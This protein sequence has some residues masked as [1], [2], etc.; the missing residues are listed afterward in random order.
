M[1][2]AAFLPAG[3]Q[4]APDLLRDRIILLTGAANG[5]GRALADALAAHGATL[6][7]LDRDVHGLEAAYDA[8]VAAGHPEPALYPMDLSGAGPDDYDALATTLERE[9]GR[10]DGLVH[11][12]AE[13]GALIPLSHFETEL[14]Y[15]TLQTDLNAPCLLTLAC[16]DLLN[17]SRDASVVFT[18]DAVGR[19]GKAYWGAYGVAKAG[20]ECFMQILAD[21]LETNTPIRANS[22]DP[23]PVLTGLRRIAYPGESGADLNRP[24]DVVKPFLFLVSAHSKG[25]TGQQLSVAAD[26]GG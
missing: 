14:W 6:V 26:A 20:L 13:L 7:L 10:L 11:N 8:I 19:H 17:A 12:A 24:A 1:S 18:S 3:W 2:H 22:I 21:E 5:I 16:L 9:F 4:P 15:R 23:G 25:I